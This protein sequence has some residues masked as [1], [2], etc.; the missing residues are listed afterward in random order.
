MGF[1]ES[2]TIEDL[3]ALANLALKAWEAPN[4]PKGE[5]EYFGRVADKAN[6][7]RK[8]MVKAQRSGPDESKED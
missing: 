2:I 8:L 1:D 5:R 3:E 6:A 4:L 7:R